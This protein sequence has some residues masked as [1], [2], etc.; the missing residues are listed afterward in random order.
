MGPVIGVFRFTNNNGL[1]LGLQLCCCSMVLIN[2]PTSLPPLLDD[3]RMLSGESSLAKLHYPPV[4]THRQ[5]SSYKQSERPRAPDPQT[6][7]PIVYPG[8]RVIWKETESSGSGSGGAS[9]ATRP[10]LDLQSVRHV[11]TPDMAELLG[12]QRLPHS[13]SNPPRV[14]PAPSAMILQIA[15]LDPSISIDSL[16]LRSEDSPGSWPR[17]STP[18]ALG[19][20]PGLLAESRGSPGAALARAKES[21]PSSREQVI[22]LEGQL[23]QQL[24]AASHSLGGQ[25]VA[26]DAAF[27]EV[28][29][30]VRVTCAEV[31]LHASAHHGA[32]SPQVRVTCAERGELL[33]T[34]RSRYDDWIAR[35]LLA[36]AEMHSRSALKT[37]SDLEERATQEERLQELL[38]ANRSMAQKMQVLRRELDWN[39]KAAVVK[40]EFDS[41]SILKTSQVMKTAMVS[42]ALMKMPSKS[43]KG[44]DAL[45]GSDT[46]LSSTEQVSCH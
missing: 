11:A 25:M 18:G 22:R 39:R 21:N 1:R 24:A 3:M 42:M 8:G 26:W 40:S 34:I 23:K 13:M 44:A 31:C 9:P 16:R 46:S 17:P 7:K 30:Q 14:P 15:G 6:Q 29:R 38:L 37:Q 12:E 36:V 20:P 10:Q 4:P 32:L 19:L 33:D 43:G 41:R 45:Q 27:A 28:A 35:L 2:T 5:V